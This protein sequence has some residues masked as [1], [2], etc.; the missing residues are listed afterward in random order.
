MHLFKTDLSLFDGAASGG[1]EAAG[2]P[3]AANDPGTTGQA[4]G[5]VLYGKQEAAP[6]ADAVNTRTES[7]KAP[8]SSSLEERRR[9]YNRLIQEEYKDFYTEDTQ[10]MI[11]RRFK[12]TKNLQ[13]Q[14]DEAKPLLDMLYQRYKVS[15]GDTKGLMAALENDDAYWSEA[16]EEAGLT[17]E[18]YKAFQKME[19]ENAQLRAAQQQRVT[20]ARA[21]AQLQHWYQEADML[22]QSF[23]NFSLEAESANPE[24]ISMLKAGVPM[25]HAYKTIHFNEIV[26]D[27]MTT[28]ASKAE[29]SVVSNIRAKG[30]RPI[31]NGTAAQSAFT[32]KDDVSKLSKKDRAEIA[33]RAMMGEKITF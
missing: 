12:D 19:R 20:D 14:I 18:Q 5:K 22:K 16:A 17:V 23:P 6:E 10:R 11:N 33:R 9:E 4:G 32:I 3:A 25:E 30:S 15:D 24:F 28:A 8:T 1:G 13:A 21:Q 29:K 7:E 31:E 26:N 2:T 27:A